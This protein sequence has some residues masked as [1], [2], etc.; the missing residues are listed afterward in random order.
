MSQTLL[1]CLATA[2]LIAVVEAGSTIYPSK[3]PL[4]RRM[5]LSADKISPGKLVGKATTN[6]KA[7]AAAV[8][9][10]QLRQAQSSCVFN[11]NVTNSRAGITDH[12]QRLKSIGQFARRYGCSF[13]YPP[14]SEVLLQGH[15]VNGGNPNNPCRGGNA[16]TSQDWGQY[17]TPPDDLIQ[18]KDRHWPATGDA[19]HRVYSLGAISVGELLW[20]SAAERAGNGSSHEA[21][22]RILT[23]QAYP[24][25]RPKCTRGVKQG[26]QFHT[27]RGDEPSWTRFVSNETLQKLT[28]KGTERGGQKGGPYG[29]G[30]Q[31]IKPA[32]V[33]RR[34]ADKAVKAI[35][36]GRPF[37][38][39]LLRRGDYTSAYPKC[40][41]AINVAR[42]MNNLS[43]THFN[44]HT[45]L[46][47]INCTGNQLNFRAGVTIG[48][49][50]HKKSS[51]QKKRG[52]SGHRAVLVG[53]NEPHPK[54][55]HTLVTKLGKSYDQVVMESELGAHINVIDN[56]QRYQVLQYIKTIAT[57]SLHYHPKYMFGKNGPA[58]FHMLCP[59]GK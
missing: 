7:T 40:S 13:V 47:M 15:N 19:H 27:S 57:W 38:M 4:A 55:L 59:N 32:L 49:Q 25:T 45:E 36:K 12:V 18:W 31:G 46:Y 3:A 24:I 52:G 48:S 9:S 23:V 50:H 11:F 16:V 2:A 44:A 14:P 29:E 43:T 42:V 30:G 6:S 56:Y 51:C 10:L 54:Y 37:D 35:F 58:P 39:L 20:L 1:V 41:T 53:T 21:M 26:V 5:A 28:K 34:M 17:V 33:V 8:A 22:E